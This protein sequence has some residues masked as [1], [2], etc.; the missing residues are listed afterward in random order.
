MNILGPSVAKAMRSTVQDPSSLIV[1]QDS[2]HDLPGT[3]KTKFSGSPNGHNGIKSI[4][5]SLGPDVGYHRLLVGIGRAGD[6]VAAYVLG[7][8]SAF[9]REHWAATGEGVDQV[10]RLIERIA[11][12]ASK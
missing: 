2:L 10:W 1:I 5:K 12:S 3:V 4:S 8:L 11:A 6:S 7:P 9:E